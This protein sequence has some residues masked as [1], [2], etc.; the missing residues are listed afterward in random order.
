[1]RQRE[2]EKRLAERGFRHQ[3]SSHHSSTG[4]A[5]S[6]RRSASS[7]TT[8]R[9]CSPT[10]PIVPPALRRTSPSHPSTVNLEISPGGPSRARL[11]RPPSP[12]R[13]RDYQ[14]RYGGGT[15]R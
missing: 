2:I 5:S 1:M 7:S 12:F 4:A 9:S 10:S 14:N 8:S 6:L 13:R 11:R 3:L 15:R